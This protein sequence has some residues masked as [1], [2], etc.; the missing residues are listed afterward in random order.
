MTN[1]T[2][3][4]PARSAQTLADWRSRYNALDFK[5][6][7]LRG[8]EPINPVSWKSTQPEEQ[9]RQV[10]PNFD[11][12]IGIVAGN[13]RVIVDADNIDT[14]CAISDGFESIGLSP[15]RVQSPHGMHYYL[16]VA[17]V[18]GDFNYTHLA[19]E[20]FTG[21]L[22]AQ[23]CYVV[24]PC[25]QVDG[26][27]YQ[28][29]NGKPEDLPGQRVVSWKDLAWLL[30]AQTAIQ[31]VDELPVRLVYRDMPPKARG[32]LQVLKV[33][34]KGQS[35]DKY[36]SRSEAEAAV[37]SML[38]LA[39]W[40]Y[41]KILDT[42]YE[43]NPGKFAESKGRSQQDYFDRTHSR[44]MSAIVGSPMRQEIS[45]VWHNVDASYF[46]PG[47]NGLLKQ[48]VLLGL[49]AICWQFGSWTVYASERDLAVYASASREGVHKILRSLCEEDG[50]LKK[51]DRAFLD[52][53]NRW[54]VL[55]LNFATSEVMT[56]GC[57]L[58]G[59]DTGTP[60]RAEL[61]GRRGLGRPAGILYRMLDDFPKSVTGLTKATG[62]AWGTV[63]TALEHLESAGLAR[64]TNNRWV[65]GETSVEQAALNLDTESLLQQ[66]KDK[67]HK[68]R[69]R[70]KQFMQLRKVGN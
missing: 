48:K 40:P 47:S 18:P 49:L 35:I 4:F 26:I 70:Y 17:D 61:W 8:K 45:M 68:E 63:K 41:E 7:P 54:Q 58:R 30:P 51:I 9:W 67:F 36:P 57:S 64:K 34:S 3:I 55:P 28:W 24:A 53:S 44:V 5:T 52:R 43:W 22:R 12:N 15:V 39:G 59:K 13:S 33:A 32:L 11:G 69:E 66:R 38:I 16:N 23:N 31:K 6:I 10:G 21:E 20:S 50:H 56:Y 27:P 25:S 65:R 19:K 62:K 29:I 1:S 37:I 14:A 2:R 42:F 60:D 46:W